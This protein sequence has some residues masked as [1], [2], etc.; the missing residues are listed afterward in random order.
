MAAI[1]AETARGAR[2]SGD[3]VSGA[4]LASGAAALF[5]GTLFYARL[6]PELGLPALPAE[7]MQAW[8]TR[9][10][11]GRKPWPSRGASPSWAIA[12]CSRRASSWRRGLAARVI[13]RQPAGR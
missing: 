13:S 4:L 12:C 5:V 1:A 3:V 11:S 9:S 6:T 10:G 8:P 7:R 2:A